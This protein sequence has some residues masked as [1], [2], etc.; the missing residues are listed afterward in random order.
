MLKQLETSC[1]NSHILQRFLP[2][3]PHG[4]QLDDLEL[5]V[6]TYNC[7]K[8]EGFLENLN[9][10]NGKTLADML[11][12]ENFGKRSLFDL[13]TSLESLNLPRVD[14]NLDNEDLIKKVKR[15]VEKLQLLLIKGAEIDR[16]DPR[17]GHCLRSIDMRVATFEDILPKITNFQKENLFFLRKSLP[18]LSKLRKHVDR[19]SEFTLEE[20][21][22]DLIVNVQGASKNKNK[23]ILVQYLGWDGQGG[24]TLK[25]TGDHFGLTRERIRQIC[26]RPLKKL[27]RKRPFAPTT[28]RCLRFIDKRIPI[29]VSD[30]ESKLLKAGLTGNLFR[31]EGLISAATSFGREISFSIVPIE[32]KKFI[33]SKGEENLW[34]E[35]IG[36]A[37]ACVRIWGV[38]TI[39]DIVARIKA[40][41]ERVINENLVRQILLL[42]KDFQWLDE[43]GGWFW[44]SSTKRNRVVNRIRKV[45]SVIGKINVS[46]LRG[47]I[48]RHHRMKGYAPTSRVLLELCRRLPG[49]E[50]QDNNMILARE[51]GEKPL[52]N[53]TEQNMAKILKENGSIMERAAFE[54]ICLAR[55]I[56]RSTFYVY[57]DYCPMITRYTRG[58]YGLR[59]AEVSPGLVESLIPN[60]SRGKAL[61]DCGWTDDGKAWLGYK[62]NSSNITSGVFGA[63]TGL[64]NLLQGKFALKAEDGVMVGNLVVKDGSMWGLGRFFRNRGGEPGDYILLVLN[65]KN[66]EATISIG[67]E[68]ILEE[69]QRHDSNPEAAYR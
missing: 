41:R 60:R 65:L 56:N 29:E 58:V 61:Q 12:I 27:S 24:Q 22:D 54:K 19:I 64:K 8:N 59:G 66:R 5:E 46:E 1:L 11:Q 57:L 32:G 38:S 63:P 53:K 10:L 16:D 15:E 42:R 18:W 50:V 2:Y 44:F 51:T 7:L 3:I 49:F 67:A 55:G 20:E 36:I 40:K 52:L 14:E 13:L 28:D 31:P 62:L 30:L 4:L 33:F 35:I 21:L 68:D 6:R 39:S 34:K 43:A 69:F 37:N 9:G 45:L 25:E 17:L 47:G 26:K 23:Q 48:A